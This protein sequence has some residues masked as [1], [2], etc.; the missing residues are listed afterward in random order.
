MLTINQNISI[1]EKSSV[2]FIFIHEILCMET[3]KGTQI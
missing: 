2:D 1:S 3:H